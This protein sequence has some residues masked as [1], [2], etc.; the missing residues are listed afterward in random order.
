VD[1]FFTVPVH[2]AHV[3][4]TPNAFGVGGHADQFRS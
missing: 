3:H 4:A 2:Q 1:E